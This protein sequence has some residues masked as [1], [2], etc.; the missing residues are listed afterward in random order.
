M[1]P[2]RV[3]VKRISRSTAA[4]SLT[5]SPFP[6]PLSTKSHAINLFGDPR[7]LNLY[8]TIFYKNIRGRGC[9]LSPKSFPCH[10]SENSPVTPAIATDPKMLLSKSCIC[11][12]SE[13]PRGGYSR[14]STD[15]LPRGGGATL[16]HLKSPIS[17]T[18]EGQK[19]ET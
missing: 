5:R 2:S 4:P 9:S 17:A 6:L 16:P 19:W 1:V 8:A 13:T 15:P 11:H 3:F 14:P 12:T 7:P 18:L 10:T